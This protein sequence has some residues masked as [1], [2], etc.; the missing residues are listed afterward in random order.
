MFTAGHH[1]VDIDVVRLDVDI[2]QL[3]GKAHHDFSIVVHAFLEHG[4]IANNHSLGEQTI[5][6]VLAPLGDLN[7]R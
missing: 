2:R 5:H 6:R 3:L 4:L 7:R 1:V